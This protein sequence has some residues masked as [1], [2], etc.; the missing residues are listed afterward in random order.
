MKFLMSTLIFIIFCSTAFCG[1]INL[2][3]WKSNKLPFSLIFPQTSNINQT[4]AV[5]DYVTKFNNHSQT[6]S[7]NHGE[8]IF[9]GKGQIARLP[10]SSKKSRLLIISN[11]NSDI[12]T[13]ELNGRLEN[14]LDKLSNPNLEIYVLPPFNNLTLTIAESR[15]Y[16]QKLVKHFDGVLAL[17]GH[18]ID[19]FL[20]GEKNT[21]T[22]TQN[23]NRLRDVSEMRVLK[24]FLKNPGKLVFGICRGH[25]LIHV[26][27][28][29]TLIQDI[30]IEKGSPRHHDSK[31]HQI[32]IQKNSF[33]NKLFG[34]RRIKVKSIHHQ[35]ID[36]TTLKDGDEI[37][38]YGVEGNEIVEAVKFAYD[39][40]FSVQFH[41][42]LQ[43][44]YVGDLTMKA[45]A[46][47][48]VTRKIKC[49]NILTSF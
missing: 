35:A 37:V 43:H 1:S 5:N 21:D 36:Q 13:K 7:F 47:L 9:P 17:G 39:K 10:V 24:Q 46:N 45:M 8:N 40:G 38:A 11:W 16:H 32:D 3:S 34:K 15:I 4:Q 19:P 2:L 30:Y 44:D 33:L 6:K 42:E 23:I 20:Y 12:F 29:G 27:R 41:P 25:Q 48:L 18:D 31:F 26:V 22:N 49:P 14:L 28:G